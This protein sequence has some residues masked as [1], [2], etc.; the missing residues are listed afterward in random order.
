MESDRASVS[1]IELDL[2][3]LRSRLYSA[4]AG[5]KKWYEKNRLLENAI[6][7]FVRSAKWDEL[8]GRYFIEPAKV[9]G[10]LK[11]VPIHPRKKWRLR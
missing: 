4:N 8:E 3:K 5:H 7:E 9:E 1:S 6:R 11:R 10:M 2:A